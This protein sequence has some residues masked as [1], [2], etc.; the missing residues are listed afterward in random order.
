MT[1]KLVV[2]GTLSVSIAVP[3]IAF[4]QKQSPT[5]TVPK[6]SIAQVR[7]L[8]QMISSNKAKLKIYCDVNQLDAQLEQAERQKDR[9]MLEALNAKADSLER[10]I[11]AEYTKVMDSLE[12]IDP[13]FVEGK[14]FA[15]LIDTLTKQCK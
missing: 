1:P 6:P 7:K 11:S 9:E 13:N 4:A 2:A 10:Q 15:A 3:G 5:N 14:Q 12:V 8:V